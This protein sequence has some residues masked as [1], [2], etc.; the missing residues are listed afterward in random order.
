MYGEL[1]RS[2]QQ[3]RLRR[4]TSF[5]QEAGGE[6]NEAATIVAFVKYT[7]LKKKK[8]TTERLNNKLMQETQQHLINARKLQF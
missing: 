3:D 6:R 8:N 1:L 7:G 4:K 5:S 2:V